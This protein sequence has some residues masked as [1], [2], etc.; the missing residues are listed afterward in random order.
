MC[1]PAMPKPAWS[2]T[3]VPRW[4]PREG[5]AGRTLT[6]L[7]YA[8]IILAALAAMSLRLLAKFEIWEHQGWA[9]IASILVV[10]VVI[11]RDNVVSSKRLWSASAE[12]QAR[13]DLQ[14]ILVAAIISI[15]K[16]ICKDVNLLCSSV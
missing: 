12:L 11:I 4:H 7:F 16:V 6:Q 14:N 8:L 5:R 15:V 1:W 2:N 13:A 10:G 9:E 3:G